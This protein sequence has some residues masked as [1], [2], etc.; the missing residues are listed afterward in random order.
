MALVLIVDDHPQNL[1]MLSALLRGH[2]FTVQEARHGAEALV[3]ARQVLPDL[4]VSDLLMPVM[5]GYTLLSHWKADEQLRRVPFVVYTA[6]YT[7]PKDEQLAVALGADAFIVKPTDPTVFVESV[8]AV[9]AKSERGEPPLPSERV[10][11]DQNLLSNYNEVLVRK[12]EKRAQQLERSNAELLAKI[13]ALER[14]EAELLESDERFRATFEQ[15]AV[16]IAHV[17]ADGTFL[18]VNAKLCEMMGY[19][20]DELLRLSAFDLTV[21]EDRVESVEGVRAMLTG[22]QAVYSTEK[23]YVRKDGV[24]FWANL[25]STPLRDEAGTPKYLV[26]VITDITERKALEEQL[27]QVQKLEAVGQLT[28]GI[29][30]D[31]NNLLTVIIGNAELLAERLDGDKGARSLAEMIRA[32]ARRGADLTQRLLAF[33]RRQALDPHGV[34]VNELLRSMDDML[35]RILPENI[36]VEFVRAAGLWPALVDPSQLEVAVLNLAIN[37]R[38][39]M[40]EGGRLTIETANVRLSDDYARQHREVAAGQYVLVAVSDTGTGME[41]ETLARVFE[42]FFTTKPVGKGTG[43]GLSM[44]Y[45]FVKQSR[46][47]V[48]IYSE[49][50]LG[51]TVKLYLPRASA[52]DKV[53]AT[54]QESSALVMTGSECILLVEDDDL[55]RTYAEQQ[56]LSLGYRVLV[57]GDGA[58]ALEIIKAGDHIDLLFTDVVMP[59][60]MNGKQLADAALAVR[61]GLKTLFSSGYTDN[62]IVHHGRLDWGVQLLGKPYNRA[63][64]SRKVRAALAGPGGV[65]GGPQAGPRIPGRLLILDDDQMVG[66]VLGMAAER[67]GFQTRLTSKPQEF[68]T[69]I[70]QWQPSHVAID[71]AMPEMSGQQV[72][73]RLGT[74]G[75]SARILVSSG[76]DAGQM[77]AALE[78]ARAL[79]LSVAGALPK[80]FSATVLR[81]LLTAGDAS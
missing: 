45:G 21:S 38:D 43:L 65:G 10:F 12:L 79:G 25:V 78:Q 7:E 9:L 32:A 70:V 60:G 76:A 80:P 19:T 11:N 39:A 15:A 64:L 46:G 18:R 63:D 35:R 8:R 14:T 77:D 66:T 31:F 42:P 34:E 26:S 28:G 57:A 71:L 51:T 4:V 81:S 40:P 74:V 20:R 54:P 67:I 73:K 50:G 58:A 33:A 72:I 17:G 52:T 59:R 36:E 75:C 53:T 55:V 16:G 6:T 44:V 62:A 27:H 22:T 48:N 69:E 47:H 41:P 68:F 29:A 61:P 5:D 3:K 23:R 49:L 2:G 24:A 13:E 37:A 30:H 56:L 1:Y